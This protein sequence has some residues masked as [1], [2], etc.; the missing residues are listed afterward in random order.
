MSDE[1]VATLTETE[2]YEKAIWRKI[3]DE[4][5]RKRRERIAAEM[6]PEPDAEDG[7]SGLPAPAA[8]S[9]DDSVAPPVELP[10]EDTVEKIKFIVRGEEGNLR[11][12][13]RLTTTAGSICRHFCNKFGI[14]GARADNMRLHFD[15]ESFDPET[16]ISEMDLESGDLVDVN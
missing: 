5:E 4:E 2:G 3:Q 9:D 10:T 7:E 6:S 11:L 14:T 1:S 8:A 15:G 16:E 13:V 12:Q